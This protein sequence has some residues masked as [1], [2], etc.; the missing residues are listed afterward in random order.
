MSARPE[1]PDAVRRLLEKVRLNCLSPAAQ[2][3]WLS[4]TA[5]LDDWREVEHWLEAVQAEPVRV[6]PVVPEEPRHDFAILLTA[7]ETAA[8]ECDDEFRTGGG[9]RHDAAYVRLNEARKA[10]YN[11]IPAPVA[12]SPV[13]G[14][15]EALAALERTIKESAG[16]MDVG[17][18]LALNGHLNTLLRLATS[19]GD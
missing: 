11:A 7:V 14:L 19:K 16:D 4:L 1:A 9:P 3:G 15:L 5:S 18:Y 6:P 10:L 17:T 12:P 13:R 2:S 8:L